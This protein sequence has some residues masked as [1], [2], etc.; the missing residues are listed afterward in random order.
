MMLASISVSKES[1]LFGMRYITLSKNGFLRFFNLKCEPLEVFD[2][3]IYRPKS[4]YSLIASDMVYM[5]NVKLL[6]V[7]FSDRLVLLLF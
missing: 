5:A 3:S 6:A 2:L 4:Y 7:I 1:R